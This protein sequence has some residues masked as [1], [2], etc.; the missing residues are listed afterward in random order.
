MASNTSNTPVWTIEQMAERVENG[1]YGYNDLSDMFDTFHLPG[2]KPGTERGIRKVIVAHLDKLIGEGKARFASD[3]QAPKPSLDDGLER[4]SAQI[5]AIPTPQPVNY[6]ELAEKVTGMI[7]GRRKEL[8]LLDPAAIPVITREVV[9]ELRADTRMPINRVKD[10]DEDHAPHAPRLPFKPPTQPKP[11]EQVHQTPVN[12]TNHVK[13][14]TNGHTVEVET[15]DKKVTT[16]PKGRMARFF[17][18]VD[19][20][21]SRS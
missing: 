9:D 7:I 13:V 5:A 20:F 10:E 18:G 16:Q 1:E 11:A 8:G 2:D 6:D 4:L 3:W 17:E 14:E 19:S 12:P 21:F 15:N